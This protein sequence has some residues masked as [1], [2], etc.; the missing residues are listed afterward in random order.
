MNYCQQRQFIKVTSVEITGGT[1]V[2]NTGITG[3]TIF[4]GE[5]SV[6]CICSTI[7]ASTTVVP[8][9]ININ[10]TNIAMQDCLGNVLQSDQIECRH[11]YVGIWGTL[12][13]I[14]FK[15]CTSTDRS[16]ATATSVIPGEGA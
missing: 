9:V 14:H 3:K 12:A 2:L 5:K 13:P 15:L 11:P 8:V 10:G 6:I 4:N 7:P 1:M 16:Q